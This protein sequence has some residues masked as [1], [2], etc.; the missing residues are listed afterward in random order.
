[1]SRDNRPTPP[2]A[3]SGSAPAGGTTGSC[4]PADFE[5]SPCRIVKVD[6]SLQIRA[7]ELPGFSGGTY[8]W[9]TSSAKIT[10]ANPDSSTVTVN[11][12]ADPSDG[13]DA[14]T[15]TVTRT[16]AGCP[17]VT[18]TVNLTVAK[19]TFSASASQRYGYD[20]FDT[21]ANALDDHI[22]VK[23][24]DYTFL[25]VKIEGGA[26]GTDFDFVCDNPEYCTPVEPGGEA[27]FDLRLDAAAV[28]KRRTILHAKVKCPS[29]V[30]F[31]EIMVHVYRQKVVEVVVG[32][33]DKTTAGTNLRFPTAD[34][35]AHAAP[36]NRKLKE[37]VVKYNITNFDAA[38]AVTAV[39][40]AGGA[41][42]V[43][44]D[45]AAGGGADLTAIGAAM[46][47]TGTKVRVAIIRDMKSVYYLSAAAAVGA[48]TLTVT[49]AST[50]FQVGDSPPVGTGATQENISITAVAGNTITCAALTQAHAIGEAIEFPAAGWSSDPILIIEGSASLTVTKWTVLHEVGHRA[51]TLKDI[52]DRADFMHFSQSWTDYR[53]RYCPRRKNYPAG[54]RHTE[55][56][57]ETIPRT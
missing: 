18:K 11:A 26:V 13:R 44:Y 46:P 5:L 4:C 21:P 37:A 57:W 48:T 25:H 43:T 53:L 39:N 34:Y 15:I 41:A 35:A 45:I 38:N 36:A 47:G 10:L 50:F 27:E 56:Q 55:N 52:R 33:F 49:A 40:L 1:M 29:A 32:K 23:K 8:E 22:C 20:N 14:E 31:A 17:A 19:V 9:T 54:T 2:A 7:T 42:T 51:L 6:G 28:N 24:S 12:L 3:D 30:S 16:A